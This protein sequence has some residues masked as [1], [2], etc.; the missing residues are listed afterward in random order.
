MIFL[1]IRMETTI[2]VP[3]SNTS[4]VIFC[5]NKRYIPLVWDGTGD[6]EHIG[7]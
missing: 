5:S 4:C 1:S 6:I 3:L 2:I 7:G